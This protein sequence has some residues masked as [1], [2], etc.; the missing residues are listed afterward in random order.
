MGRLMARIT[1]HL[2]QRRNPLCLIILAA[3]VV[4]VL[5]S[6]VYAQCTDSDSDGFYYEPGGEFLAHTRAARETTAPASD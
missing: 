1:R 3:T 6:P 2:I 5:P 4:V